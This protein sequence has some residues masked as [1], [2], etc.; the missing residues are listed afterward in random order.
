M[1]QALFTPRQLFTLKKEVLEERLR[2]YYQETQDEK[3]VIKF[4]VALQV[5]DELGESDFSFFLKDLVRQLFMKTKANRT[6]RRYYIFFQDYFDSAERK[7]ITLRLRA[8]KKYL[9]DQI[10]RLYQLIVIPLKN[11]GGS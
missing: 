4:L 2:T 8:I 1:S 3:T 9:V 11:F 6:L 7:T 10:E 5:R